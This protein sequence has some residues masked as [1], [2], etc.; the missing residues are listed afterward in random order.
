MFKRFGFFI[1][2]L[3]NNTKILFSEIKFSDSNYLKNMF[4]TS[5]EFIE[6][7]QEIFND[8]IEHL[9]ENNSLC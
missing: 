3:G 4:K 8:M 9:I 2:E 5:Q 7:D 1:A 6:F